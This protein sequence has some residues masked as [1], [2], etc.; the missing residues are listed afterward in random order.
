M[1]ISGMKKLLSHLERRLA[2]AID[3][4]E[5]YEIQKRIDELR[6]KIVEEYKRQ[7]N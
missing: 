7:N 4:T 2:Y 5:Y 1:N 3:I 6:V